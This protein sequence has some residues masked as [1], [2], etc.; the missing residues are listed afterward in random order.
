MWKGSFFDDKGVT[1]RGSFGIVERHMVLLRFAPSPTGAL[2]L[3]GLRT[4]LLNYLVTKKLH[5]KWIL[6]IEDTDTVRHTTSFSNGIAV[7]IFILH[8]QT[9]LVPGSVDNIRHALD[10]AGLHYD[11]GR[12]NFFSYRL[13]FGASPHVRQVIVLVAAIAFTRYPQDLVS[14]VPMGHISK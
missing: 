6:R 4:A 9:R 12:S 8:W 11:Y 14:E 10:W 2:H 5:G 1:R 13:S 7:L 3:G